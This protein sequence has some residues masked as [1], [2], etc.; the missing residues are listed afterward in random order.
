M[1]L[2]LSFTVEWFFLFNQVTEVV[3]W[4]PSECSALG[5]SARLCHCL[6]HIVEFTD[7]PENTVSLLWGVALSIRTLI[8]Q[9]PA[10]KISLEGIDKYTKGKTTQM[11]VCMC[12]NSHCCTIHRNCGAAC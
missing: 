10:G 9:K 3:F 5:N 4:E 7:L 2:Q 8:D 11:F 1:L 6:P 12:L